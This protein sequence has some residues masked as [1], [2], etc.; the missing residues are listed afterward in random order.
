VYNILF[1]IKGPLKVI[2]SV[3]CDALCRRDELT[4]YDELAI[5]AD[6]LFETSDDDVKKLA[7][8]LD[9]LDA[10]LRTELITSDLL[11]A[12]QVFYYFFRE[13]PTALGE[14]RLILQPASALSKGVLLEEIDLME[15]WFRLSDKGGVLDVSD[16]DSVVASF[17]GKSA[18]HDAVKYAEEYE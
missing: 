17:S 9:P 18:Y 15:L 4:D 7:E 10:D 11:N 14:E 3:P 12:W 13:I 8:L 1:Y 2:I 6:R 16:G 5:L